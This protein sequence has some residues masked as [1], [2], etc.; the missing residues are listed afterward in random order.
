MLALRQDQ[1]RREQLTRAQETLQ[2]L[3]ARLAAPRSR[4]RKASQIQKEIQEILGR[5]TSGNYLEVHKKRIEIHRF[6]QQH[7]GDPAPRPPTSD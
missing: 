6:K 4:I 1:T 2:D 3:K 5:V 7:R